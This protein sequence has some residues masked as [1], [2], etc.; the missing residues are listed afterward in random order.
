MRLIM[1]EQFGAFKIYDEDGRLCATL[2]DRFFLSIM[3]DGLARER[4]E[5]IDR[6][7]AF[8][9]GGPPAKLEDAAT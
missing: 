3:A 2:H 9:A 4:H 1:R 7:G 6:D 5:L 8:L